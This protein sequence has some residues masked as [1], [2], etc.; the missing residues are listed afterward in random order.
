MMDILSGMY[1][2]EMPAAPVARRT[3]TT[4]RMGNGGR[5]RTM[6]V[7]RRSSTAPSSIGGGHSR[8][9]SEPIEISDD[10]A[11]A[12]V[13]TNLAGYVFYKNFFMYFHRI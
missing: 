5:T 4:G 1:G 9:S 11:P 2:M 7:A 13:R 10:E 3:M 12:R 8:A 6:A